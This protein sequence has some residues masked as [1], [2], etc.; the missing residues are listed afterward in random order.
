MADHLRTDLVLAALGMAIKTRNP[1]QVVHHSDQ[2]SQYTSL[3]FSERCREWGVVPVVPALDE[4]KDTLLAFGP[5][6]KRR[7]H[8]QFAFE[9]R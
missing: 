3:A 7:A 9:R 6:F 8:Q 5:R 2:G 1:S 4:L